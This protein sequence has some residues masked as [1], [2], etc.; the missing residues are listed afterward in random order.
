MKNLTITIFAFVLCLSLPVWAQHKDVPL[1]EQDRL[2][3][4]LPTGASQC[5]ANPD[6]R[7]VNCGF[8]TGGFDGWYQFDICFCAVDPQ[9]RHSGQFGALLGTPITL[10]FISQQVPTEPGQP[11]DLRFWLQ[12][13]GSPNRF[14][15][16]WDGQVIY[17]QTNMPDFA[18]TASDDLP[19]G[20]PSVFIG[21]IPSDCATTELAFGFFNAPDFFFFDDVELVQQP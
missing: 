18:Y 12:N 8:E 6:N 7:I 16:R 3:C 19:V 11:Y 15:V 9:A 1:P 17:D 13:S 5:D 21:L 20:D 10:S 4:G 2:P 14:Q